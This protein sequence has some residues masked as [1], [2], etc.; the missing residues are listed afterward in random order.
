[1]IGKVIAIL[2][3]CWLVGLLV[4]VSGAVIHL[5]LLLAGM[6]FLEK[7]LEPGSPI[8]RRFSRSRLR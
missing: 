2:L 5:L 4:G 8:A 1:M 3:A 6:L 7:M